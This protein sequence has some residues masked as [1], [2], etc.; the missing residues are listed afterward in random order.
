MLRFE[1][2]SALRVVW[3]R[4]VADGAL[5]LAG[6]EA[7]TSIT[8]VRVDV[9]V[10]ER[11]FPDNRGQ[12][13]PAP[14][15]ALRDQHGLWVE[16]T[17]GFELTV[18]LAEQRNAAL[19]A[20]AHAQALAP[21]ESS[22]TP[23][24]RE[25]RVKL[26]LSTREQLAVAFDQGLGTGHCFIQTDTPP[27]LRERVT[28]MMCLPGSMNLTVDADV[29]HRVLS[30]PRIGV[31]LQICEEFLLT[32]SSLEALLVSPQ[33]TRRP[34]VLAVDDEALWRSTYSRLLKPH[35]VDL[36]L[37]NDGK[38]GLEKLIDHYFELDLVVLDLHM[39]ELDGRGLIDRI[40]RLGG[41]NSMR[42]FLVSAAPEEELA[43]LAGPRGANVVLS[44]LS[45]IEE[46]ERALLDALA[47]PSPSLAAA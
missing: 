11:Q 36:I 4:H 3:A 15:H 21:V 18:F 35:G 29:I 1:S 16:V 41:E 42:L 28:L 13:V 37:A 40:R 19:A 45:P 47:E 17:P 7:D 27:P 39:P 31:G 43:S 10:G 8:T 38:E 30:G 20:E 24:P 9:F 46:I 23:P 6:A 2:A 32:V 14:D 5:F 22:P 12:I 33:P 26:D 25:H 44:K 34:R